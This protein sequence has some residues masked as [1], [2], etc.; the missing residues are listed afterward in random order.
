MQSSLSWLHCSIAATSIAL[1]HLGSSAS[2]LADDDVIPGAFTWPDRGV[3]W[4]DDPNYP[5]SFADVHALV[6]HTDG[7]LYVGGNFN[8]AGDLYTPYVAAWDGEVWHAIAADEE[9]RVLLSSETGLFAGGYFNTIGGVPSAHIARWDGSW[10][11]LATGTNGPVVTMATTDENGKPVLYVGGD[12]TGAG[13]KNAFHIARWDGVSWSGLGSGCHQTTVRAVAVYDDGQGPAVYAAGGFTTC[14]GVPVHGIAKWDG[15]KWSALGQGL[16]G[17]ARALA[18]FD[19]GTGPALYVGGDFTMVDGQPIRRI[20]RWNGQAWSA[21]GDIGDVFTIF[22]LKVLDDGN[23][24]ALYAAGQSLL[25]KWDGQRWQT[26]P[27]PGPSVLLWDTAMCEG[28]H[29]PQLHVGGGTGGFLTK[30]ARFE[31]G[32][33]CGDFNGDGVT[34][35]ADLGILL[36]AYDNCPGPGCQGDTDGD[37][38]V[39]QSDLGTLLAHFGQPCPMG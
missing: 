7:R 17:E 16:G 4:Y 18:V 28:G 34:D 29:G 27:I 22:S 37:G 12:F 3:R 20:A 21:V 32:F 9:L 23:G 14:G 36:A 39:D 24:P 8:Y 10:Q 31:P 6:A 33:A 13:G 11:P 5:D 35:Q 1:C 15:Q 19:D 30:I 26:Y 2:V 38:D 25:K